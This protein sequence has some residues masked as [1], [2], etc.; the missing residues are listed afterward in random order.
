METG[1]KKNQSEP[2]LT[3]WQI[4]PISVGDRFDQVPYYHG[5]ASHPPLF[6]KEMSGLSTYFLVYSNVCS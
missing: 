1:R 2:L 6:C 4:F 3:C 5:F